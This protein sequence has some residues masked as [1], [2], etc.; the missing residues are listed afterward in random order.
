MAVRLLYIGIWSATDPLSESTIW[1]HLKVLK[2]LSGIEDIVFS[3]LERE[4]DEISL[5]K[6]IAVKFEPYYRK[7]GFGLFEN[8]WIY[9]NYYRHLERLINRYQINYL[10]CRGSLAGSIGY[11]LG[12]RLGVKLGVESFEPH[13]EYMLDA[14]TWS[15]LDPRYVVQRYLEKKQRDFGTVLLPVSENYCTFLLKE[16]CAEEKVKLLPCTV[17]TN[18]FTP[19][20]D[21]YSIREKLNIPI[22]SLVGIYVGKFGDIYLDDD[23]FKIFRHCF[24]FFER[25]FHLVILTPTSRSAVFSFLQKHNINQENVTIE[26]VDKYQL[27]EYLAAADFSFCTV[28]PGKSRAYCCPIKNGEYW[29]MGLPVVITKGIGDDSDLIKKNQAGVVLET[30]DWIHVKE[31]LEVLQSILSN[32]NHG[33]EI[34]KLA[35][36]KRDRSQVTQVYGDLFTST[37]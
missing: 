6:N 10:L 13:A 3:S 15:E 1:P 30:F 27:K 37:I 17:D 33:T 24:R 32:P 11:L 28:R 2:G 7:G 12:S 25:R 35:T 14:G 20:P 21:K 29:S 16:G 26:F 22:D 8:F 23:A 34:R 18:F 5:P 19:V 36:T 4:L 31:R 9:Y